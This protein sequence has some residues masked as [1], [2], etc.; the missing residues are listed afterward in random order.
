MPIVRWEPFG[1]A[2][3]FLEGLAIPVP[4]MNLSADLAVDV[5]E[6]GD[7]VVAKMN[8]PGIDPE[9][10]HISIEGN[11]LRVSGAHEEEKEEINAHYYYKEIKKGLSERIISLP[12]SV[13]KERATAEYKHG[14][15]TIVLPKEH[16]GGSAKHIDIKVSK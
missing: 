16:R 10:I 5:Y 1:V 15:L 9:K 14:A 13:Q 11:M 12:H 8:I 7:A 4:F 6:K 3:R 2:Q